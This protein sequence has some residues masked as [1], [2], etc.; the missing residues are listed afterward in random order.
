MSMGCVAVPA[1]P[2]DMGKVDEQLDLILRSAWA[3]STLRTRDSQWKRY[4]NF[5]FSNNLVPVPAE[6]STVA[7]FLVNLAKTCVF[8]T[9]NNYLSSIITLHKFLGFERSFR[10]YFVISMVMQGLG[11]HLGKTVSQKVGMSPQDF[12]KIHAR[13]DFSDVNV[14]T[15]WGALMLAF[16]SLLRKSNIVQTVSGNMDMVLSRA[17]VEFTSDGIILHVRKTKTI[18]RKEYVLQ[19][20]V[21][22]VKTVSLCAASMLTTH[23]VRTEHIKDGPLFYLVKK[24]VWKPLLY[25]DLLKFLKHCVSLIGLRPEEVGLHSMRR[26]GA[27]FLHSIGVSLVDIMNAGD[28]RSLA[29]LAYLISPL[30]RKIHIE[31]QASAALDRCG[32]SP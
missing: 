19:I 2:V 18:Q 1:T 6:V 7:R 15:M 21:Y 30:D 13:L 20:P 29:A 5:C 22:Y 10:D 23:M 31:S 4:I 28:W 11:R 32:F 25:S 12:V 8:S 24:G 16:R 17:D 26:S 27:A 14:I 9:C 3:E